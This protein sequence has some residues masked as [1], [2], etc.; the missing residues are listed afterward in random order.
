MDQVLVWKTLDIEET[1]DEQLIKEA[2]H[3]RL[4]DVNPE[5]DAEGFMLLREAYEQAL[6]MC[7]REEEDDGINREYES[8]KD[9]SDVDRW[10]YE[11]Y[12][13]YM[14]LETRLIVERWEELLHAPVAE[15]LDMEAECAERLLVFLMDHFYLPLAVWKAIDARFSYVAN[16]DKWREMFPPNFLNYVNNRLENEELITFEDFEGDTTAKTDE[17]IARFYELKR[18]VDENNPETLKEG[19]RIVAEMEALPMTHPYGDCEIALYRL[20]VKEGDAKDAIELAEDY[21]FQ[22]EDDTYIET[23]CGQIFALNDMDEEAE[24][25]FLQALKTRDGGDYYFAQFGL[26]KLCA[27]QEK[28]DDAREYSLQLLEISAND[29]VLQEFV[30]RINP[31]LIRYYEGKLE[32]DPDDFNAMIELVWAH[33]Q[34]EDFELCNKLLE[35]IPEKHRGEYEFISA[36]SRIKFAMEKY[37]VALPLLR[38]WLNALKGLSPDGSRTMQRRI[39]RIPFAKY[40]I[41]YCMIRVGQ[42]NEEAHRLIEEGAEEEKD[43]A[44][45][46]SYMSGV[47]HMYLQMKQYEKCVDYATRV[48]EREP[49][50]YPA[51]LLREEAHFKL[52]HAQEVIDDYYNAIGV[53]PGYVRPYVFAYKVFMEYGQTEDAGKVKARMEEAGLKS[54]EI[55]LF[56]LKKRRESCEDGQTGQKILDDLLAFEEDFIARKGEYERKKKDAEEGKG[57]KPD[58]FTDIED[59]AM[60]YYEIATMHRNFNRFD[61]AYKTI[62]DAQKEYPDSIDLCDLKAECLMD[63]RKYPEALSEFEKLLEKEPAEAYYHFMVGRSLSRVEERDREKLHDNLLRAEKEFKETV[64][65]REDYPGVYHQLMLV[66]RRLFNMEREPGQKEAYFKEA[67]ANGQ[68]QI[69][70][71]ETASLYMDRGILYE[72]HY[73]LNEA[74]ADY[75]KAA[76][77]VPDNYYYQSYVGDIL[78]KLRRYDEAVAQLEKAKTLYRDGDGTVAFEY[79]FET[80][81]CKKDYPAAIRNLEL[82]MEKEGASKHRCNDLAWLYARMGNRKAALDIYEGQRFRSEFSDVDR[83]LETAKIYSSEGNYKEG[84]KRLMRALKLTTGSDR[85]AECLKALGDFYEQQGDYPKAV[86]YAGLAIGEADEKGLYER[87]NARFLLAELYFFMGDLANAK[88]AGEDYLSFI[89]SRYG[90]EEAFIVKDGRSGIPAYSY[91]IALAFAF[92]GQYDKVEACAKRM[93]CNYACS[94]CKFPSCFEAAIVD[95]LLEEARGNLDRAK[96]LYRIAMTI[97]TEEDNIAL[98]LLRRWNTK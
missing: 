47:A 50:Y 81:R 64:R 15:A 55:A 71:K 9:G 95:G 28:W 3:K 61:D 44:H 85:H 18:I 59:E 5:E 58:D 31:S 7:S 41:G 63:E 93:K 37:D 70:Y 74:L 73:M 23:S 6:A 33:F 34:D 75:Q 2:Y 67:L 12:T 84:E 91:Y 45:S 13:T 97:D 24:K 66:L 76:E 17:Y 53:Y 26:A 49:Q 35:E 39:N 29:P 51:Y 65:I 78:R 40:A 54:D 87:E 21:T 1:L 57:E 94:F 56:D 48:V 20:L 92:I 77:M 14:D 82:L 89:R 8:L 72:D 10:I 36:Y 88:I 11:I 16:L 80:Y 19:K 98:Y 46:L 27:K 32:K 43:L 60:I 86:K 83:F 68:K 52:F 42:D 38:D 96:E 90:S 79:L 62:E 25:C 4:V 22:Y 30:D 69:D